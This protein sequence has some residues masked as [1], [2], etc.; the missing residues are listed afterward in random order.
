MLRA[1]VLGVVLA[2]VA[3]A[4]VTPANGAPDA[5][6]C[7]TS[8]GGLDL[9]TATI[10]DAQQ[11]MAAGRVT[12]AQLVDAYE[13]RIAAYDTSG[14]KLNAIRELN[15]AA[16]EQAEALDAERRAGQVRGP[17]HGVPILVKDNYGTADEPTT[18]GSIALEGVVPKDD[19][20]V[21]SKLRAAGA[22]ILGKANLSEF[23]GWVDLNMPAGYS[24]LAGQVINAHDPEFSPSGS[25]AGSGVAASM[26]FSGATLGTETSGSIL[27]PSDANGDVGV[28]TTLGLASRF[29]ILPLAPDF[30]VP[31]PIVRSVTDAAIVLGAIA[32]P[33]PRDPAT[34]DAAAHMPPG[35]DY[36]K[37]LKA[38]ALKGARL[39]YSQDA[40]DSLDDEHRA[41]FDAGIER[42]RKLGATVVPVS[43][44]D[45]ENVGLAEIAAVPNEFKAS[46]NA[47]L[48][49]EM[50]DAQVHSLSDIIAFNDKHP[51]R[52][53]YGQ[54][55]LQASDATPG[56]EELFPAQAGPSQTSARES[57]DGAL[58]EGD[59]DAIITPGNAHANV[60][61]A[62]GYPTVIEP[63][64]YT[65]GGKHPFGI[66]FLGPAFS[67]PM[68]LGYAYAYEQDAHARV[69]PDA[70]NPAV[71]AVPCAGG[72]GNSG[73]GGGGGP[74]GK[75]RPLRVVLHFHGHRRLRV[76]V[77]HA[78]GRHILVTVRHGKRLVIR[79]SP[80]V[81][82][83]T[84]HVRVVAR[85]RGVYRVVAR[86]PGPPLRTARAR[87]RVR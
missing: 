86:D 21:V 34:A 52:V 40:H 31:G 25:S 1:G 42:L 59:A 69:P 79:R 80:L 85:R 26:A 5:T 39:A 48:A 87:R 4:T 32:G 61:A 17:L 82:R 2:A 24:S 27:S 19:A 15:P 72:A 29:G 68:L 63:L 18:A 13:A 35:G 10:A 60:G 36:T 12:S 81:R 38:D 78:V 33:D 11:A 50:P 73:G 37:S 22:V 16:R 28:K 23:A 56:R 62:A 44:F 54:G 66:G 7:V 83:G 77:L 84:T 20:T 71:A 41:L 64:G 55:L 67:E 3:A 74:A 49:D 43:S 8:V 30:D 45:S 9:Q 6:A 76:T 51:D 58:A 75:P 53:K 65:D 70:V 14:P 57:I 47:Y 46:L